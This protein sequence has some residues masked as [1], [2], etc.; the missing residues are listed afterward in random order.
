MVT[1][2]LCQ[3]AESGEVYLLYGGAWRNQL[4]ELGTAREVELLHLCRATSEE[5]ELTVCLQVKSCDWVCVA[6]ELIQLGA[7]TQI[8][9]RDVVVVAY[10]GLQIDRLAQIYLGQI[11]AGAGELFERRAPRDI[12]RVD[13]V[14]TYGTERDI[15]TS[16]G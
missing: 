7:A 10:E 12:E 3:I 9:A 16:D 6:V 4:L 15:C 14:L 1:V 11:V 5:G 13:A 8:D 2:D